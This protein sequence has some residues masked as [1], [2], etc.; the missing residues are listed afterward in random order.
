MSTPKFENSAATANNEAS[1][2]EL[3][4]S[5][6]SPPTP[7]KVHRQN[8]QVGYPPELGMPPMMT[9]TYDD[10]NAR[11]KETKPAPGADADADAPGA[12]ADADADAP[13]ADA[14][15]DAPAPAP[16]PGMARSSTTDYGTTPNAKPAPASAPAPRRPVAVSTRSPNG[17]GPGRNLEA[18]L[19][20]VDDREDRKRKAS[21]S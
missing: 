1:T 7:I 9:R 3:P 11:F 20:V 17:L 19:S 2:D 16:A 14:D 15:A 12:D 6:P 8:G 10:L 18:A 5:P 21:P 4:P 13:E